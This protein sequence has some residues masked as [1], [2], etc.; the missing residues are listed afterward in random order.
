MA[1][2][3]GEHKTYLLVEVTTTLDVREGGVRD[4]QVFYE[5]NVVGAPDV[6]SYLLPRNV[7]EEALTRFQEALDG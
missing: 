4:G 2:H 3:L 7:G 1:A 5:A 6:T